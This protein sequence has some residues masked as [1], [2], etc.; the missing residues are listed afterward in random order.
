MSPVLDETKSN[1]D[2]SPE[3]GDGGK[4]NTGADLSAE[5]GSG[6][7][8]DGVGDEEHEGDDGLKYVSLV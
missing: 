5:E 7:L 2:A 1:H 8:K 6:R 3:E 4:E